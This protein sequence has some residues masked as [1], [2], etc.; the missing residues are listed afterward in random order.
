MLIV[1][2]SSPPKCHIKLYIL[3]KKIMKGFNVKYKPLISKTGCQKDHLSYQIKPTWFVEL[4]WHLWCIIEY[5][6]PVS[7]TYIIPV[8]GM[9]LIKFSL[10][11]VVGLVETETPK[12]SKKDEK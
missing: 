3:G 11:A 12:L 2:A 10:K 5:F 7:Q 6:K 8:K 1:F 9:N 4:T